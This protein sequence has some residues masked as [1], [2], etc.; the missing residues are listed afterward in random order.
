MKFKNINKALMLTSAIL[1]GTGT[2]SLVLSSC[3]TSSVQ[4]TKFE[5]DPVGNCIFGTTIDFSNKVKITTNTPGS[6]ITLNIEVLTPDTLTLDNESQS[7]VIVTGVGECKVK[8]S[9]LDKSKEVSFLSY[10]SVSNIR[11]KKAPDNLLVGDT[12]NLDDYVNVIVASPSGA[13]GEYSAEN[14]TP[15][16]VKLGEDNKTL[17]II[18]SGEFN[19]QI[20]DLSGEKS[21]YFTGSAITQLQKKF[22]DYG[23]TIGKNYTVNYLNTNTQELTEQYASYHGDKYY[24]YPYQFLQVGGYEGLPYSGAIIFPSNKFYKFECD[25]DATL[26]PSFESLKMGE[27]Q[28]GSIEDFYGFDTFD[29]SVFDE[30]EPHYNSSNEEDYLVSDFNNKINEGILGQTS[31]VLVRAN[32]YDE[33]RIRFDT[34]FDRG[35][36]IVVEFYKS[37]NL[38]N[39]LSISNINKTKLTKFDDFASDTKNEPAPVDASEIKTKL[40]TIVNAKNYTLTSKSFLAND[41]G[42]PYTLDEVIAIYPPL[43]TMY[44]TGEERYTENEMWVKNMQLFEGFEGLP[45]KKVYHAYKN[46]DNKVY[47]VTFDEKD[48]TDT[49]TLGNPVDGVTSYAQAFKTLAAFNFTNFGE[50]IFTQH[51]ETNDLYKF[52]IGGKSKK[53]SENL[54]ALANPAVPEIVNTIFPTNLGDNP[55]EAGYAGY[56]T[57]TILKNGDLKYTYFVSQIATGTGGE[58]ISFRTCIEYTISNVGTTKIDEFKNL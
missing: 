40:Q 29:A 18:G 49:P 8:L 3:S 26:N 52:S 51:D 7:S 19:I 58:A 46:K 47:E 27:L 28:Q 53:G 15:E 23:A 10:A 55:Y 13:K 45:N 35:E 54:R 20:K 33:A 42:V 57:F 1:L 4:I 6:I 41:E 39:M 30:F 48:E 21:A 22:K 2:T 38:V 34:I 11:V 5:V 14:L 50:F 37:N 32:S 16:I 31:G 25:V 24:I 43:H 17:T 9:C 36:G 12:L 56:G 44:Y